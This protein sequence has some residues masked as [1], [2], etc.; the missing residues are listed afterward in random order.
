MPT[1]LLTLVL[2]LIIAPTLAL[3]QSEVY[4]TVDENGNVVFTDNPS[5]GSKSAQE[6]KIPP[7]NSAAPPPAIVRPAAPTSPQPEAAKKVSVSITSPAH[8]DVIPMGPGN[9]DVTAAVTPALKQGHQL[10]LLIDAEPWSEPQKSTL[11]S[12]T[13]VYHGS[14]ILLVNVVD[15]E[16]QI[17]TSSEPVTVHVIRTMAR[18]GNLRVWQAGQDKNGNW[19]LNPGSVRGRAIQ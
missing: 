7:V 14:H 12:M 16:G 18:P 1:R 17:L 13:N 19:V 6:V 15:A 8:E 2:L 3:G 5:A 11:W 10:Q 9:F 4:K